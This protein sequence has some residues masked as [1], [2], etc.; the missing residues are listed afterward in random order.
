M[1]R[2][3]WAAR[4][5][6]GGSS[7]AAHFAVN[8]RFQRHPWR[9]LW[10][11][12]LVLLLLLVLWRTRAPS[13]ANSK[14][15]AESVK[16]P[17]KAS[18]PKL[19]DSNHA[20]LRYNRHR[21]AEHHTL[22]VVQNSEA[23]RPTER[24]KASGSKEKSEEHHE[25]VKNGGFHRAEHHKE[26][27]SHGARTM[28]ERELT[29]RVAD[30]PIEL[31]R[32]HVIVVYGNRTDA[33]GKA[34]VVSVLCSV[35]ESHSPPVVFMM[36]QRCYDVLG[37]HDSPHLRTIRVKSTAAAEAEAFDEK[38]RHEHGKAGDDGSALFDGVPEDV[39]REVRKHRDDRVGHEEVRHG[40]GDELAEARQQHIAAN[41]MLDAITREGSLD[42]AHISKIAV[43]ARKMRELA[44]RT[45]VSKFAPYP[46]VR[47]T[48]EKLYPDEFR[49]LA[50]QGNRSGSRDENGT[51]VRANSPRQ[52]P[53]PLP[54][55]PLQ[56]R[57][58]PLTLDRLLEAV[59]P[60]TIGVHVVAASKLQHALQAQL[61]VS[62]RKKQ[63]TTV[64]T[65]LQTLLANAERTVIVVDG[66]FTKGGAEDY[67]F[68]N[69]LPHALVGKGGSG[70][71]L[72]PN[73]LLKVFAAAAVSGCFVTPLYSD[74]M[75]PGDE[76]GVASASRRPLVP[77]DK[78]PQSSLK[79][80]PLPQ[81]IASG[82]AELSADIELLMGGVLA[83]DVTCGAK[84]SSATALFGL[85][86]FLFEQV[87]LDGAA[88][89]LQVMFKR[90]LLDRATRPVED[91]AGSD[92]L[93]QLEAADGHA[94]PLV[95]SHL[96]HGTLQLHSVIKFGSKTAIYR[97]AFGPSHAPVAVKHFNI[98]QYGTFASFHVLM[99]SA[100]RYP[101]I[102]YPTSSCVEPS[103]DDSVLQIQPLL[104]GMNLKQYMAKRRKSLSWKQRLQVAMQIA[105][106]FKYLHSH[107]LGFFAFDD[108]HPE[109]Y[110]VR[111]DSATGALEVRLV[112]ID[113][114]QLGVLAK[115][116]KKEVT[117]ADIQTRC[118]C[119]YCDGRSNC[120]FINTPEGYS[121]CAQ[122]AE[123]PDSG[124][125]EPTHRQWNAED[126][127]CSGASDAW[128]IAQLLY[129]L[130]DG[131]APWQGQSMARVIEKLNHGQFP[132]ATSANARYNSIVDKLFAERT[133]DAE[134][135]AALGALC[136]DLHCGFDA[137][138]A[139]YETKV[140]YTGF[141][142]L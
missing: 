32:D 12:L 89:A 134:V 51:V 141:F 53:S 48:L 9:S 114:V 101:L 10:V 104:D 142:T 75:L 2:V 120:L 130:I 27:V 6:S 113:T 100:S 69:N 29:L 52:T 109:Q 11:V 47:A 132:K 13:I 66:R 70:R 31:I 23:Q 5:S 7:A 39:A 108:N 74:I 128:F 38:R 121:G 33:S 19:L 82:D 64:E 8:R 25:D 3:N 21:A 90:E 18:A 60:V 85:C 105:C 86:S 57:E 129:F 58:G 81:D 88:D 65:L 92:K 41:G 97:G 61:H 140:P 107:P 71:G 45:V 26:A 67:A 131:R 83:I 135:I 63:G 93:A 14:Q 72:N 20:T 55:C 125:R 124:K 94:L 15:T 30:A 96:R 76:A 62:S 17:S 84:E 37:R 138:P 103:L 1:H 54:T 16:M 118:R 78:A 79:L 73:P 46:A 22:A 44:E 49:P 43:Q 42:E 127:R 24:P 59:Q 98:A 110:F 136:R 115:D 126:R 4:A 112:D 91:V 137:C 102:N 35:S 106:V 119:F 80:P 99:K 36:A 116:H 133:S 111:E 122:T 123:D 28:R 34:H 56:P 95:C 139:A 87:Q 50:P 77:G 40:R 68:F 117:A